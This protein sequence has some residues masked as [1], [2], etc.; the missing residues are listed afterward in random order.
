M[1]NK[2]LINNEELDH[3]EEERD[4]NEDEE[5]LVFDDIDDA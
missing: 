5:T 1:D 2:T 4:E 3:K